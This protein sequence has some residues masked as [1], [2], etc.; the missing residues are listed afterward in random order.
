MKPAA[1]FPALPLN[2]LV[3]VHNNP[4]IPAIVSAP[5]TTASAAITFISTSTSV[6]KPYEIQKLETWGIV[7]LSALK[8]L[9]LLI[10]KDARD[11]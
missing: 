11:P 4:S 9:R 7:R 6:T 2:A 1:V 5:H 8:L 3:F 10:R